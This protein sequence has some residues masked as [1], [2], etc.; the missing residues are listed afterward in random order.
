MAKSLRS[1]WKRKMRANKRVKYGEREDKR[2]VKMLEAA[3]ELKKKDGQDSVMNE[4]A[5]K[6]EEKEVE[7]EDEM[8]MSIKPK[9]SSK[10]LRDEHGNFPNWMSKRK[11]Q[12]MKKKGG[13]KT[14]KVTKNKPKF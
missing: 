9:Y 13:K 4:E 14:G 2:L 6:A 5:S 12:K 11:I 10:T 8:D 7:N 3:E 1:K